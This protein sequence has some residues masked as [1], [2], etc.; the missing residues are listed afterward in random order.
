M[1]KIAIIDSGCEDADYGYSIFNNGNQIMSLEENYSEDILKHGSL[2]EKMYR[3]FLDDVFIGSYRVFFDELYSGVNE[4]IYAIE[5]A[6]NDDV[7]LI[8]LSCGIDKK[9]ID[10]EDFNK[11]QDIINI[12]LS[13][14]IKIVSAQ[15][16]KETLFPALIKGVFGVSDSKEINSKIFKIKNHYCCNGKWYFKEQNNFISTSGS[17]YSTA[18]FGSMLLLNRINDCFYFNNDII[19]NNIKNVL[20]I[21][22]FYTYFIF[23]NYL[24]K[25]KLI[26]NID[27]LFYKDYFLI[28]NLNLIINN[29]KIDTINELPI[30]TCNI[31]LLTFDDNSN[32]NINLSCIN[33]YFLYGNFKIEMNEIIKIIPNF[34]NNNSKLYI[35]KCFESENN[36]NEYSTAF[37]SSNNFNDLYEIE[38]KMCKSLKRFKVNSTNIGMNIFH[39]KNHPTG[40]RY[41][42]Y[43]CKLYNDYSSNFKDNLNK[44]LSKNYD[45]V[46]LVL[47]CNDR[48][49]KI[50]ELQNYIELLSGTKVYLGFLSNNL[51]DEYLNEDDKINRFDIDIS[52][53]SKIKKELLSENIDFILIDSYNQLLNLV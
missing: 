46:I 52:K 44:F 12:A 3:N 11:L 41:D 43:Y 47:N 48:I 17:S 18:F 38:Y 51:Y 7:D 36:M 34:I 42:F 32:I 16:E 45:R 1:F 22:D 53:K 35:N 4:V 40:N 2:V 28:K 15:N 30:E 33:N 9:K 31:I 6:I 49:N 29:K 25:I 50:K 8:N 5:M 39:K 13:K 27:F 19:N 37:I 26:W 10:K 14:N 24:K 23:K 20:V 21:N